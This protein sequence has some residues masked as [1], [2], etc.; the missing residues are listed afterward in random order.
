MYNPA[1]KS[2]FPG[3]DPYLERRWQ[4]VH[5]SICTY[6]PDQ[7]QEQLGG[8]LVARLGE[9]LVVESLFDESRSIYPDVRVVE[10]G[11]RDVAL[12]PATATFAATLAE[13]VVVEVASDPERQGY[14]E[15]IEPDSA[16]LVTVI[17]FI[18]PSN[19][20][21]GAGRGQY[22]K[23]QR[24]LSAAEVSLVEIDLLRAGRWC[25][26]I[27]EVQIPPQYRATYLACVVRGYRPEK[28]ELYP[29]PLRQRLPAIRI[30][31][32]AGDPDVALDVQKL[33]DQSYRNGRHDLSDYRQ[34]CIPPLEGEDAV[35]A[36]QLLRAAGRR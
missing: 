12:A 2:P 31:L 26:M 21:A 9:R 14:V 3:M 27:P 11:V 7:L 15:I 16:K 35:W 13:P 25:F 34:P 28:F 22:E 5:H 18:S 17:E 10:H 32:R 19:K 29:M 6:A 36:D 30:P 24:E 1:M 33:V 23:K 20:M 8:E 4:D